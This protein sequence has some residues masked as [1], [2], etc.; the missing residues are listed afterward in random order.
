MDNQLKYNVITEE[1]K[2]MSQEELLK[3]I[4]EKARQLDNIIEQQNVHED[5]SENVINQLILELEYLKE[6]ALQNK[7]TLSVK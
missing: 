1:G 3:Q 4:E 5:I 2:L 7:I 6:L